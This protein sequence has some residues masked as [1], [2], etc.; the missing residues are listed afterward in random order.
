MQASDADDVDDDSTAADADAAA[1][2]VRRA[3]DA[4]AVAVATRR[5]RFPNIIIVTD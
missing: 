5:T 1:S 3:I 2:G 4:T